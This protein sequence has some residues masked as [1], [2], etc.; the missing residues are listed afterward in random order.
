MELFNTILN[1]LDRG[2]NVRNLISV[3]II[4]IILLLKPEGAIVV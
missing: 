2:A 3:L 4:V 1:Q